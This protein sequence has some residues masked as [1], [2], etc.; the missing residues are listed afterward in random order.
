MFYK[1]RKQLSSIGFVPKVLM[2]RMFSMLLRLLNV[3]VSSKILCF[4]TMPMRIALFL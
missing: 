4:G 1:A 3:I 2:M